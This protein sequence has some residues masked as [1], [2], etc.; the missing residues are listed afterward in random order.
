M[1]IIQCDRVG[2]TKK[3]Q[4]ILQDVSLQISQG[5]LC[6]IA[7]PSGS[8]K[9]SLLRLINLLQ[10][11]TEG[12]IMYKNRDSM[13]LNP[14]QLRREIGY[15]LQKPYLFEGTVRDNLEYPYLVWNQRPDAPEISAYLDKVSL[16]A[17][18]LEKCGREMSGGE[19]QRVAFIRSLLAKPEV[20]LLDEISAA[21]DED[22]TLLVEQLIREEQAARKITVLL[23]SHNMEQLYRL[24]QNIV[25]MRQG[26]VSFYGKVEEF[27]QVRGRFE[28]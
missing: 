1:V 25:Y 23:I 24:A 3:G 13:Q 28:Q 11:P 16:P 10:S 9:T 27:T 15:V 20:L 17:S 26:Q 19:Q 2:L 18:I 21:L 14:L 6:G 22:N 7:G 8:G 4:R 5:E 12:R